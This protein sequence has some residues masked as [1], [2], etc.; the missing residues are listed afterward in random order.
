[1]ENSKSQ[2]GIIL[3]NYNGGKDTIEC[4]ESLL[5]LDY[6]NFKIVVVD[7]A[8]TDNS[9]DSI[10]AWSEGR[11]C[12]VSD[13]SNI[14]KE[15]T[16]PPCTKPIKLGYVEDIQLEALN[17]SQLQKITVL[18]SKENLGFAGGN[19]LATKFL[20]SSVSTR[21]NYL[22]YLNNDTIVKPNALSELV[23]CYERQDKPFKKLGI[24]GSKLRYYHAENVIQAIGATYNPYLATIKHLGS[25]EE[26]KG[27]FDVNPGKLN[28]DYVV[29]ASMFVSRT[30]VDEVG[31]MCEEYFLYFEEIDWVLRG[32]KEGYSIS[33]CPTSIVYHKEG[34]SIGGGFEKKEKSRL[35]DYYGIRNRIKFTKKF[36]PLYLPLVYLSLFGVIINRVRRRQYDRIPF[37]LKFMIGRS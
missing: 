16:M 14:S 4:L 28:L 18:A 36:Y 12:H 1:M 3:V 7:N 13:L 37:I 30:F 8:S 35:S 32:K 33:Y 22:W 20:L 11:L 21:I 5:K 2:V 27:Q 34:A 23:A 10:C 6:S 29:G 24:L 26:D 9:L 17:D 31:L 19:N 15:L 25:Q